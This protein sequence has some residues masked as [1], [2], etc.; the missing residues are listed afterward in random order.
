MALVDEFGFEWDL[1]LWEGLRALPSAHGCEDES[2]VREGVF[3]GA[4]KLIESRV[5]WSLDDFPG[6]P[7]ASA[8]S[9]ASWPRALCSSE[10]H[11]FTS[12]RLASRLCSLQLARSLACRGAAVPSGEDPDVTGYSRHSARVYGR[13]VS[14]GHRSLRGSHPSGRRPRGKPLRAR[15]D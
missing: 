6:S 12:R 2:R 7:E 8:E 4:A 14:G 15:V 11:S 9:S 1:C 10:S 13:R 5:S 3:G